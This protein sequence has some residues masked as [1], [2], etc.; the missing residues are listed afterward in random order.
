MRCMHMSILSIVTSYTYN[1]CISIGR[2][3]MDYA[4]PVNNHMLLVVVDAFSKWIEVLP[5]KSASSVATIKNL[6][7]LFVT[8]GI[9]ESIV[10]DNGSPF[11]SA[12]MKE[13]LTGNG[14]RHITSSPY[15]SSSNGLAE[16]VVQTCKTALKKMDGDSLHTKLQRFF[17]PHLKLLQVSLLVSY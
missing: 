14:V 10:S 11:I 13:F 16:R 1:T 15:H 12:E 7:T 2:L 9:P 6:R 8:H 4:G 5:V 3:H 17:E